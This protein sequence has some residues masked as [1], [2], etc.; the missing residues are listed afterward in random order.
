MTSFF[1]EPGP[2][3][4]LSGNFGGMGAVRWKVKLISTSGYADVHV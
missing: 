4:L 3:S 2:A 1:E